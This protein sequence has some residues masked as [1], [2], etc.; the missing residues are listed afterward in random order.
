MPVGQARRLRHTGV[1]H[2]LFCVIRDREC[3]GSRLKAETHHIFGRGSR[4][5]R[6]ASG[7][8]DVEMV[9]SITSRP[10]VQLRYPPDPGVC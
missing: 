5:N 1:Y 7:H 2:R 6:L 10:G 3:S 8:V 9:N 4:R